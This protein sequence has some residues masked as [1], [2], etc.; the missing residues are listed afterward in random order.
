M[1]WF[2]YAWAALWNVGSRGGY[3]LQEGEC[4]TEIWAK[5]YVISTRALHGNQTVDFDTLAY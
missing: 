2:L 4:V 3:H 5:E 1:T